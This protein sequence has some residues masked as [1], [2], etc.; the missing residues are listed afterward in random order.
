VRD[1]ELVVLDERGRS[2]F[3]RLEA[4]IGHRAG[5]IRYTATSTGRQDGAHPRVPARRGRHR[6][7]VPHG[8]L[9]G[10][11]ALGRLAEN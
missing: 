8:T 2:S 10:R 6:E 5:V 1:R 9:P 3:Q 11:V 4:L 7:Q